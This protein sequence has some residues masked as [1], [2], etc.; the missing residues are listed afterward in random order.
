MS[1]I[2][3]ASRALLKSLRITLAIAGVVSLVVGIL[4]LVWPDKAAMFLITGVLA[5]W[6]IVSGIIYIS[7]GVF[8]REKTGWARAGHVLLGVFYVL[9]GV[10]VFAN[11]ATSTLA[12]A[13]FIAM[14]VGI[15]WIVDGI[16]AL[17][18]IGDATSKVWTISYAVIAILGGLTLMFQPFYG[19]AVLWWL[20]GITLVLM[21]IIQIIRAI[22]LGGRVAAAVAPPTVA[23]P[24]VTTV[25][26]E[27]S[28]DTA[29][30][31]K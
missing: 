10:A 24:V 19:A 11:L 8:S 28:T 29:E 23:A 18:L 14:I 6:L 4:I 22:T 25:V 20:L 21:G 9:A 27:E 17:S 16:V 13:I 2:A 26:V 31:G 3:A 15:S 5:S 12:L 30:D 1:T 7:V